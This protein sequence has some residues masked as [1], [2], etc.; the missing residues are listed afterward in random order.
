M[1]SNIEPP[2]WGKEY[3]FNAEP[4]DGTK[5][6]I[7]YTQ[8]GVVFAGFGGT[9]YTAA[10]EMESHSSYSHPLRFFEKW[11]TFQDREECKR[12]LLADLTTLR[13]LPIVDGV[14]GP[15]MD[16][17][18]G[19]GILTGIKVEGKVHL[20]LGLY[21][22]LDKKHEIFTRADR[23]NPLTEVAIEELMRMEVP[24]L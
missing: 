23:V 17:V 20:F 11:K 7:R 8:Q 9:L 10:G 2:Q 3:T 19:F 5:S 14:L 24:Q 22:D 13:C 4:A 1:I 12:R 15:I 21:T 16:G 6:K 18:L